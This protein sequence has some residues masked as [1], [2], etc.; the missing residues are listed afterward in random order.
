VI[1]HRAIIVIAILFVLVLA[2]R[3]YHQWRVGLR[4]DERA[5]PRVPASLT[6]GAERT[7][8]LFTTPYC[9]SCGPVEQQ[10][11][12]ADPGARLVTVD[13]ARELPLARAFRVRTSPT[14]LLADREGQVRA[15]LVGAGAVGDY[16]RSP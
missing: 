7:W 16:V 13:A 3:L 4:E 5:H 1:P 15:R 2:R 12:E 9:A 8:V 6:A 14:A 11:R 10:I